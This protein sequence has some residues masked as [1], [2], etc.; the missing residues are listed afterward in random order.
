MKHLL[1][2]LSI[3]LLGLTSCITDGGYT[4]EPERIMEFSTVLPSPQSAATRAATADENKISSLWLL[5]IDPA[6]DRLIDKSECSVVSGNGTAN[7]TFRAVVPNRT[8]ACDLMLVANASTENLTAGM[9][10]EQVRETLH[11]ERTRNWIIGGD[12][13]SNHIPMWGELKNI[14]ISGSFN[15]SANSFSLRRMLARVNVALAGDLQEQF[16]ISEVSFANYNTVGS[17]VPNPG[18][19]S[20]T[21]SVPTLSDIRR[22]GAFLDYISPDGAGV[23]NTIYLFENNH[24]APYGTSGWIDNPCLVVGIVFDP[25]DGV[26]TYYRLDFIRDDD[27]WL[28]VVRNHSYNFTISAVGGKGYHTKEEALRSAPINISA[29]VIDWDDSEEI[30]GGKWAGEQYIYY[31]GLRTHFDHFGQPGPQTLTVTTNINGLT[32][33]NFV[34]TA[35]GVTDGEWSKTS[36]GEWSN[37]HFTVAI[38]T[39]EQNGGEYTHTLTVSAAAAGADDDSVVDRRTLFQATSSLMT[40]DFEITQDKY[41]EYDLTTNP[42]PNNTITVDGA[43][44]RIR[45]GVDST[46]DYVVELNGALFTEVYAS[47]TGGSPQT[48]AFPASNKA[49]WVAVSAHDDIRYG[50]F[51]IRHDDRNSPT[52]ESLFNV[53][54]VMPWIK[55]S[56]GGDIGRTGGTFELE[57]LSNMANWVPD[58]TIVDPATNTVVENVA[59]ADLGKYFDVVSGSRNQKVRLSIPAISEGVTDDRLYKISFRSTAGD[60][61]STELSVRQ[62]GALAGTGRGTPPTGDVKAPEFIL[63]VNNLGQLNLDGQ[64]E[65]NKYGVKTNYVVYFKWGSLIALYTGNGTYRNDYAVWAPKEFKG[66][67]LMTWDKIPHS[68]RKYP[69]GNNLAAG[70]GD[71]CTLASYKGEVGKFR[72]PDLEYYRNMLDIH[73]KGRFESSP[74]MGRRIDGQLYPASSYR[75]LAASGGWSGGQYGAYWTSTPNEAGASAYDLYI[76]KPTSGTVVMQLTKVTTAMAIRCVPIE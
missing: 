22:S 4:I 1:L 38:A 16:R 58:L 17:L 47:A 29:N 8:S 63:G 48:G 32:F 65:I 40:L 7:V 55:A 25:T 34:D 76:S 39:S 27:T 50:S 56:G 64:N 70:T 49:V 36:A 52:P 53:L 45:V 10:S 57:V 24:V 2:T 74:I 26:P 31:T 66:N 13:L 28:D 43:A 46:H 68:A 30:A 67:L 37:G 19:D 23:T 18:A 73:G 21:P 11:Q 59:S 62:S 20:D 6:A 75:N 69:E 5:T 72:T 3:A 54:Q 71:P 42:D 60:V 35:C 51:L 15:A 14:V 9:T 41:V 33:D 61:S 44:Q 12:D